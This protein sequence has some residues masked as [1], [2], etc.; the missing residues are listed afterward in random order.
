MSQII[1]ITFNEPIPV[2]DDVYPEG[3]RA[4]LPADQVF[5]AYARRQ[6]A[7][8]DLFDTAL[9]LVTDL[10]EGFYRLAYDIEIVIGPR[11]IRQ[12]DLFYHEIPTSLAFGWLT[13][14]VNQ[15]GSFTIKQSDLA[16]LVKNSVLQPGIPNTVE[17]EFFYKGNPVKVTGPVEVDDHYELTVTPPIRPGAWQYDLPF[18]YDGVDY[19]YPLTFSVLAP[20]IKFTNRTP[21]M[22]AGEL[23]LFRFSVE[24]TYSGITDYPE[25]KLVSA[26]IDGGTPGDLHPVHTDWGLEVTP[27]DVVFTMNIK[28]VLDIDGWKVPWTA[29]VAVTQKDASSTVVDGSVLKLN[30][31]QTVKLRILADGKPVTSLTTKELTLSGSLSYHT[32][33][34]Q[35]VKVSDGVYQFSIYTNNVSGTMRVN[36]TVNIDGVDLKLAEFPVIV[37]K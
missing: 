33:S 14:I 16:V 10:G 9:E 2:G 36:I 24:R 12:S 1:Q 11:T 20:S 34:K 17:L 32:Y 18:N 22:K 5:G 31:T 35:L 7:P 4:F 21:S 13:A 19:T 29:Y 25:V 30:L 3:Y 26:A 28:L 15:N 6:L 37:R 27:K 23:G 8:F